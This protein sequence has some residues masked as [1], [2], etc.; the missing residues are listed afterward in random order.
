VATSGMLIISTFGLLVNILVAWIMNRGADTKG[1]LN[2]RG[3]FLHVISDMVGSIGAISAA[4]LMMFLGWKW[5]DPLASI[6]VGLLALRS[7]F[8][9]T[10][11]SLHILMEGTPKDVDVEKVIKTIQNQDNIKSLHDLHIW[12]I[13]SGL[14]ALSCHVIIDDNI[15]LSKCVEILKK[16]EHKLEHLG[17]RHV[18]IQIET[19]DNDHPDTIFCNGEKHYDK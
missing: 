2:I 9:V 16:L 19:E 8:L 5:A 15:N 17:I 6:F 4:L 14:N 12:T 3:A 18:T 7:G 10:K 11:E 1:N 13:T